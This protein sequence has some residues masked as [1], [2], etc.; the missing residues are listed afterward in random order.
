M[1]GFRDRETTVNEDVGEVEIFIVKRGFQ[2]I[3]LSVTVNICDESS[4]F[5]HKAQGT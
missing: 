3:P 1:V 2:T 4:S 5:H